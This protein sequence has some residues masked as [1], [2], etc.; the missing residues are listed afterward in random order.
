MIKKKKSSLG[1]MVPILQVMCL[2]WYFVSGCFRNGVLEVLMMLEIWKFLTHRGV[3]QPS[4]R[5]ATL[6][7]LRAEGGFAAYTFLYTAL[8]T[9]GEAACKR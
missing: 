4:N 9:P 3:F 7:D 2:A 5:S 6:T 8:H 1:V